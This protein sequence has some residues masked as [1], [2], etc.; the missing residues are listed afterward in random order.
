M[1][2][3][4]VIRVKN[5]HKSFPIYARPIDRLKQFILPPLKSLIGLKPTS[6][7][8]I[9][10][11]LTDV[12]FDIKRGQTV[13][14]IGR[15]GAGKSTLLQ[16]ICGTLSPTSG[17][18]QVNG[19][20]AALL[21]LGSGFNSEYTG[22][23]NIYL[24]ARILGLSEEEIAQQFNKI[25]D[26]A[27]IGD[28]L[29]QPV[30]TYSSGMYVRLAFAVSVHVN[31]SVLIVDEALAVGDFVF[32]SRCF[33]RLRELKNQG[34]TILFVSHDVSQIQKLCDAAAFLK[35]GQLV[36]F[37]ATKVVCDE[38]LAAGWSGSESQE[39]HRHL[40]L[41]VE[42]SNQDTESQ[43]DNFF[44]KIAHQRHGARKEAEILEV[45]FNE[46][47]LDGQRIEYQDT[48]KILVKYRVKEWL[49]DLCISVYVNDSSGQL[50]LGAS[51]AIEG[52][53]LLK[54]IEGEI[55]TLSFN[56][57]NRLKPGKYSW[58]IFLVD[59]SSQTAYIDYIKLLY[60]FEIHSKRGVYWALVAPRTELVLTKICE[61][62]NDSNSIKS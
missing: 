46:K 14:V 32:Q 57:E 1:S 19:R 62:L 26:F 27:D 56:L 41:S 40:P 23:E 59:T 35:D 17:S 60:P 52:M 31:A 10:N 20:V 55:W 12:S 24:N 43:P 6:Y 21:E 42:L 50:I 11:A 3:D 48:L 30:R 51:T 16:I 61:D 38:Y 15:N 8:K 44:N 25:V 54:C 45:L 7:F 58:Q 36:L 33:E 9:F 39:N 49:A 53:S 47:Q 28:F 29:D 37:D 13:G 4:V 18:I 22:R 5:L 2:S 34:V